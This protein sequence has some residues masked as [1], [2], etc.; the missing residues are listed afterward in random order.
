MSIGGLD[1]GTT[2][3]KMTIYDHEGWYQYRAYRQYPASRNTSAHE[4]DAGAIWEA[5]KEVI[6]EAASRFPDIAAIG[7]TSFGESFVLADV[8][9]QPIRPVMLYTDPRGAEECRELVSALGQETIQSITG[10]T[11]FNSYSISKLMWAKKHCPE[12]YARAK[13]VFLMMDYIVYRLTGNA[14]I[15]YS[16]A[17]RTMA[18]DIRRLDWSSEI[19]SAAGIDPKLFSKP[20]VSGTNAGCIQDDIAKEL[21]LRRDTICVPVGHDQVA[22]A[23]GSG[24]FERGCAVD[25]AGTVECVTPAFDG[26]PESE[27]FHEGHY[28]VVPYVIPGKYVTYAYTFTGG[29]LIQWYIETLAKHEKALAAEEGK[30]VYE[31]LEG[32]RRE[33][34]TGILVLPH[35]AG[36][37]TP[38]M[39]ENAKG[40]IIGLTISHTASDLYRAMMEGVAYEM[41][42]N[43]ERLTAAGVEIQRLHA[44]GGGA[45]SKVWTQ[46]KA[47]VLNIPIVTLG[48]NE[49]GAAGCAIMAGVAAG[50]FPDLLSASQRVIREKGTCFPR[51]DMHKAY[52]EQYEKY[53]ALYPAVRPLM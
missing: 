21:G 5:V 22:A 28:A 42:L 35:F 7:V 33:E 40:A 13:H 41:C 34:P 9:G 48:S 3:C 52:R 15:D 19:F 49:A 27:L 53:R 44:T 1:I 30:S 38:Y 43:M 20:V 10:L 25:G 37:G 24:V 29:E 45:A 23:I 4:V 12:E 16:L 51:P 26:I 2:G 6:R 32:T 17:S 36:A 31:I 39:D 18:F 8:K 14:V 46:I 47:D 50:I 11:P